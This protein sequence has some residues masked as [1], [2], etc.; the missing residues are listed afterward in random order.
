MFGHSV[1]FEQVRYR[2]LPEGQKLGLDLFIDIDAEEKHLTM[3]GFILLDM[4]LGEFDVA[5]GIGSVVIRA[6]SPTDAKPL[7]ELPGEFDAFR[8]Q[9]AQ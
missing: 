2:S 7:S 4:A 6:G 5:T 9:L 3:M 1:S 8:A